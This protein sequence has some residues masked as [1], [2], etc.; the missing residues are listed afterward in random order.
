VRRGLF[1]ALFT[2]LFALNAAPGAFADESVLSSRLQELAG[3]DLRNESAGDQ[4]LGVALPRNGSGS[5][6]H[7]GDAL[8]VEIRVDGHDHARSAAVAETGADVSHVSHDYDTITAAVDPADL[9]DVAAVDGVE[10]V[11]EVLMPMT[12]GSFN[13]ADTGAN[14]TCATGTVDEGA[15]QLNTTT[16]RSQFNVDGTGVKVGILSDSYDT[17]TNASK[18]AAQDVAS[19]DLPGT[20]N[21]CGRTTPVE[22]QHDFTCTPATSCG[23][24]GRAM[25]QIVHDMA[26]GASLAFSTAEGG[27]TVFADHIHQLAASGY[28][29]IADDI[30]YFAEPMFQ[31]GII[32]NAVNEVTQQG[33]AYFSMAFNSNRILGGNNINSWEG[34]AYRP[35]PCP[36]AITT[37]GD[38]MDFDPGAGTDTT[39][40]ISMPAN[41]SI[42]IALDW[43]EPNNAVQTDM[44]LYLTDAAGNAV[45]TVTNS[46]PP[47]ATI[48]IQSTDNNFT[49]Q[50]EFE[51]IGFNTGGAAFNGSLVIQR[52]SGT[53]TPRMK[54]VNFD[55]VGSSLSATEYNPTNSTDIFGPTII[56]HNGTSG[57]QTVA[58]V[59]FN[60]SSTIEPYSARGPV[61]H[62]FGPVSSTAVGA[63]LATPEVLNKPD[64]AATDCALTTFFGSGNR[65]CGTSAAAPHA[66]GVAALQL[67]ANPNVSASQL[68]S[69][70]VVTAVPVGSFPHTA[71]GAGLLQAPGALTATTAPLPTVT[72]DQ[73][74]SPTAN[75]TPAITFSTTNSPTVV[76]CSVDGGA[77]QAC[78]SPF[79]T[80]ALADG[81]HKVDVTVSDV[82]QHSA[83]GSTSVT[84][85]TTAPATPN[86]GKGPKKKTKSNKATFTFSG[87]A[88]AAF[89]CALDKAGFKLCTSPS[90]VKV[91]KAKPKPKKH[92]F[93]VEAIDAAGNTGAPTTFKWTVVKKK[94]KH[95]HH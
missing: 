2:V 93:A 22:V 30:I 48:P 71:Q 31:D 95:H 12:G 40:G 5:L 70:Q 43:A 78:T 15:A 84:V 91:K 42:K 9:R 35:T 10:S 50:R 72:V 29:V 38:C 88:G 80:P 56:G 1:A 49:T 61:T 28:K 53:G 41:A 58:A 17:K 8:V 76:N 74:A 36:P 25:L 6:M 68:K 75:T 3:P 62:Y 45:T 19:N 64:I 54:W 24:E 33:V 83:T 89:E 81:A 21:T 26:P 51:F 11:T 63:T 4:S 23:D 55:N 94:K 66:A 44:N 20:T 79:T 34:P 90:Q 67:A 60:N 65:F 57:A 82:Y 92:T 46:N 32:A 87:E 85:D 59:P 47:P 39:F 7:I 86:I 18:H 16:A 52:A 37:G 14:N 77:A 27:E 73:P 13:D 69:D